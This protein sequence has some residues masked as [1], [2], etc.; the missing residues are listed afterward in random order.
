MN[1]GLEHDPQLPPHRF[2]IIVGK[3]FRSALRHAMPSA[4]PIDA[5]IHDARFD[6]FNVIHRDIIECL[7][8]RREDDSTV[9]VGLVQRL[10]AERI[11]SGNNAFRG[12][13]NKC[14]HPVE[15]GNPPW[16]AR[17]KKVKDGLAVAAG[18]E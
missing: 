7:Q 9:E 12:R 6:F 3:G 1:R 14:E 11:A 4:I 16:I 15:P 17:T 13:E 10:D 18:I 5:V 2:R 8:F